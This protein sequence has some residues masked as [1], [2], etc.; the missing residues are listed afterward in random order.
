[1]ML[2]QYHHAETLACVVSLFYLCTCVGTECVTMLSV[3]EYCFLSI[4][5]SCVECIGTEHLEYA[6]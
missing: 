2:L 3:L 5:A 1:M 4:V 6:E